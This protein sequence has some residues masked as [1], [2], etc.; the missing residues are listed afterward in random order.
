MYGSK[1]PSPASSICPSESLSTP[2][3]SAPTNST[4]LSS[5]ARRE[6]NRQRHA[7]HREHGVEEGVEDEDLV[8]GHARAVGDALQLFAGGAVE[9]ALDALGGVEHQLVG[10]VAVLVPL[11]GVLGEEARRCPAARARDRGRASWSAAWCRSCGPSSAAGCR[12]SRP[13]SYGVPRTSMVSRVGGLV[14]G[15]TRTAR[16][17][18]GAEMGLRGIKAARTLPAVCA[19]LATCGWV[20]IPWERDGTAAAPL[21]GPA[22]PGTKGL[23]IGAALVPCWP[24][25]ALLQS[26]TS[27]RLR[28][29]TS[30]GRGRGFSAAMTECR[31]GPQ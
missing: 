23:L 1:W 12:A 26:R 9:R 27:L 14:S 5:G 4:L 19:P 10:E 21:V 25:C 15:R 6:A 8:V 24:H 3:V 20:N 28:M 18:G 13:R 17:P 11:G 2:S 7:S 16:G 30:R 22:G 29:V 31:S